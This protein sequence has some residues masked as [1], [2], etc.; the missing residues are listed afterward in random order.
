MTRGTWYL[1]AVLV[2]VDGYGHE[3][4]DAPNQSNLLYHDL[5]LHALQW[6]QNNTVNVSAQS[7][8]KRSDLLKSP[9]IDGPT[10]HFTVLHDCTFTKYFVMLHLIG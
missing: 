5:D 9:F 1:K 10:S 8:G 6:V 4:E 2:P 3:Q 7:T